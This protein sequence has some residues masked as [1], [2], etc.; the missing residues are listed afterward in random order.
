MSSE[1]VSALG[2]PRE[3][4]PMVGALEAAGLNSVSLMGENYSAWVR[5]PRDARPRGSAARRREPG[6]AAHLLLHLLE[7]LARLLEVARHHVLH[8]RG[9]AAERLGPCLG[10]ER[11]RGRGPE[12]GLHLGQRL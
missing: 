4:M 9:L 5:A 12:A 3:T 6:Q 8:H 11:G 2:Q 1:S 10:R 7:H